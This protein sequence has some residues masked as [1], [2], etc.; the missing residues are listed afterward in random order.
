MF[1]VCVVVVLLLPSRLILLLGRGFLPYRLTLS[2]SFSPIREVQLELIL[3]QF[4]IPTLLEHG[5]CRAG[6]KVLI[7]SWAEFSA[8]LL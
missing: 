1:G 4:V 8:R 3:L 5:N 6:L 7:T 2:S